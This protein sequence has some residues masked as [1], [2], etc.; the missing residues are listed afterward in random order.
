M[1]A[2]KVERLSIA[3]G[4]ECSGFIHG[5]SADGVFCRFGSVG[6]FE[7]LV[8]V[9][10]MILV[11]MVAVIVG[12]IGALATADDEGGGGNRQRDQYRPCPL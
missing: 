2:A 1:L 11:G 3:L 10:G 12:I 5:H 9:H 4:V 6:H 7:L 8:P